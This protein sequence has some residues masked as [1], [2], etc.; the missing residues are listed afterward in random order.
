MEII[1]ALPVCLLSRIGN[2][3]RHL[4]QAYCA[5]RTIVRLPDALIVDCNVWV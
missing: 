3:S 2:Q 1:A 5:S 4:Q